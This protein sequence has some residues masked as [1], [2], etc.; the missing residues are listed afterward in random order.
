MR[1]IV[2]AKDIVVTVA[3]MILMTSQ[4]ASSQGVINP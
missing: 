3:E 2:S 4:G 1:S